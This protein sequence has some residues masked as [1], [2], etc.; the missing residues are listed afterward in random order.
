VCPQA[1]IVGRTVPGQ[2]V[3]EFIDQQ[4]PDLFQLIAIRRPVGVPIHDD[5]GSTGL[6]ALDYL[7]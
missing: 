4:S 7:D 6:Q 1:E 3:A 5:G 2:S